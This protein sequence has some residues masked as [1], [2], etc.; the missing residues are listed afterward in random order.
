MRNKMFFIIL[1]IAI[2]G[3]TVIQAFLRMGSSPI[4]GYSV[5][6][7]SLSIELVL[8]GVMGVLIKQRNWRFF[9]LFVG[10]DSSIMAFAPLTLKNLNLALHI[11]AILLALLGFMNLIY[12]FR[13]EFEMPHKYKLDLVPSILS[14]L[15][16]LIIIAI[17]IV[18]GKA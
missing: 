5:D 13:S 16:I 11:F 4:A 15:L 14:I 12:F 17:F 8:I 2:L 6:I 9:C 3:Y 1:G 10:L 7:Y 18:F